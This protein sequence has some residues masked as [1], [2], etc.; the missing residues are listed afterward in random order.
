MIL[1]HIVLAVAGIVS[2]ACRLKHMSRATHTSVRTQHAL[3]MGGINFSLAVPSQFA[4][5][6]LLLGVVAFLLLSAG[7]WR[8][9][10]PEDTTRPG[11][12]PAPSLRHVAGGVKEGGR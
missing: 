10:A 12:L 4:V 3:L 11:D 6:P 2:I 5:L 7:R 8:H 9:G 1:L